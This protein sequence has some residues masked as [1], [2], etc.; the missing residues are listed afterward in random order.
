MASFQENFESYRIIYPL[1][2]QK[3]GEMRFFMK[4]TLNY[5]QEYFHKFSSNIGKCSISLKPCQNKH[6]RSFSRTYNCIVHL[7]S[8][9]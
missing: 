6:F 7:K 5:T 2:T 9:H 1:V 4:Y 3:Y 8:I